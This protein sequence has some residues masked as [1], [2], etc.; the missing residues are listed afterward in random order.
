[1]VEMAESNIFSTAKAFIIAALFIAVIFSLNLSA[2][3]QNLD[4]E[5]EYTVKAAFILKFTN[6]VNW[7][8]KLSG[9]EKFTMCF[10]GRHKFSDQIL[11][12][13][14]TQRVK[15]RNIRIL[16]NVKDE[17]LIGNNPNGCNLIFI[18]RTDKDT[19]RNTLQTISGKPILTVGDRKDF[20]SL[21]GMIEL[22]VNKSNSINFKI[23]K[24][25]ADL[26][27]LSMNSKLLELAKKVY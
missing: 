12:T 6:F 2:K 17:N 8:D 24:K 15:N 22:F 26:S 21:G 14:S 3:A 27:Q 9:V 4:Q 18:G 16:K 7:P 13:L 1:M 23:N 5:Q 10:T 25:S 11:T 20:A 19:L